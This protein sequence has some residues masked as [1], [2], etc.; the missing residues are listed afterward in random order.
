MKE[1]PILMHARSING[2]QEK[3]KSQTRRIIKNGPHPEGRENENEISWRYSDGH[4]GMG[5]Y[6]WETEYPD[7]GAW[8]LKCPYG[9]VGDRLWVRETWCDHDHNLGGNLLYRANGEFLEDWTQRG[10]K[11]KP[12]IFMPR[13][14][15]RLTLEITGI[16]I[17]RVQDISMADCLAEG[18]VQIP[19]GI[20]RVQVFGLPDWP[21]ERYKISTREVF[22]ELWD[23]TNGAGA[24]ERNDWVWVVDFR[25]L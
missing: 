2:I 10:L 18:I 4:S 11:W 22:A 5:W 17:E 15:S 21:K 9:E 14:A 8:L 6:W 24:W 12:S 19:H 7:D 16:R 23:D 1:R 3:R 20:L 25:E 13:W